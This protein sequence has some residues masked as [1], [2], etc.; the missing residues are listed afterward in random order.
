MTATARSE[1]RLRIACAEADFQ[2][3]RQHLE[4]RCKERQDRALRFQAP[5]PHMKPIQFDRPLR[6]GMLHGPARA[7]EAT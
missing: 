2:A 5:R 4:E 7:G 6:Y 1:N 3:W